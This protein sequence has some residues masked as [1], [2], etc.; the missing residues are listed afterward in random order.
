VRI[1]TVSL[2][3]PPHHLGGY[4]L[5]CDGVMRA[6]LARGH[7]VRILASDFRAPAVSA[8]DELAVDREL[9]SY[10]DATAE[11]GARLT[12]AQRLLLER[13]NAAVMERALRDFAP[14][15]VSWWGMGGMSLSLIERVR[16]RGLA[17]VLVIQDEWLSYGF[18]SDGWTRMTRRLQ[19]LA[20]V[21]EPALGIPIRY[22][23]ERAGRF[24]FN[25]EHSLTAAAKAGIV[26]V[27]CAVVTSGVHARYLSQAPSEPWRWRLLHVGRLDRAKGIDV[28]VA[29][30]ADLPPETTLTI[31]GAGGEAYAQSLSRQADALGAG[32]RVRLLG[33]VDPAALPALYAAADAVVF[34]IRWEEPWGLV[35]LEAMGVG[36]PVVA[37][38]RG[39]AR[40]YLRDGE[41]SL[42]IPPEDP[43]A[44]AG[45]VRRLAGDGEL[46]E[47]LRS[48]GASTAAEHSAE[49]YER[50]V[51]DELEL[52]AYSRQ[53][54]RPGRPAFSA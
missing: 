8:P 48:G 53:L 44:L 1:L 27:D 50:R 11:R 15:V 17:S 29:A 13:A 43:H 22:R 34:P 25:S 10:L 40:T 12:P 18:Q 6:A 49:R 31:V 42:L 3:Y 4:E 36:R 41:N 38:A 28:A 35:P 2:L 52:A 24:L 45:A 7:D 54:A 5:I 32:G 51:V 21:L 14:D 39:G 33:P 20:P 26:P 9:R 23:L 30:L 37:V 46:R 47:R 16:R 19:P